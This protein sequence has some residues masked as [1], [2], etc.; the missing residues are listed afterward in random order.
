MEL[1]NVQWISPSVAVLGWGRTPPRATNSTRW[2][3][4]VCVLR[5][6]ISPAAGGWRELVP[7]SSSPEERT[8]SNT[9]WV[10]NGTSLM[11][12]CLVMVS[13]WVVT[14]GWAGHLAEAACASS[15][16]RCSNSM[17]RDELRIPTRGAVFCCARY[18]PRPLPLPGLITAG[19]V[20]GTT[21]I[22]I[23]FSGVRMAARGGVRMAARGG[24]VGGVIS[25]VVGMY[26]TANLF[27]GCVAV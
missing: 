5:L 16:S 27:A 17:M 15:S 4:V 13:I 24:V 6:E 14:F 26:C 7:A 8:R 2:R 21:S 3:D 9:S 25:S 11:C 19:G 23:A 10:F 1:R 18:F 20:S 12:I 22:S